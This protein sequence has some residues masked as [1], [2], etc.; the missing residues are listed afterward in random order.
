MTSWLKQST[1]GTIMLG[2]FV[3]DTDGK[4]AETGLTIA[5]TAVRLSKAGAAFSAASGTANLSHGENGWYA[6]PAGTAD[7]NTLGRLDIACAVSGA[8]PVWQ[9]YM[10]LS[11]Q[12]YNS[13][14]ANS[15]YLDVNVIEISGDS[16]AADNAEAF[17][18]GTGYAG[19]NNVIPSVTLVSGGTTTVS[20]ASYTPIGTAVWGATTRLITG[21]TIAAGTVTAITNPVSVSAGTVAV[22]TSVTNPVTVSAGTTNVAAASYTPIGTAVWGS[23]SR[24]ITGGTVQAGT[25]NVVTSVAN[26]VSVN[27][28]TVA[29]AT[30]VTN[31]VQVSGGT[32]S[33]G[34]ITAAGTAVEA[35]FADAL[36][37]R[38]LGTGTDS[39]G[40]TVRNAL[41]PLVNKVS[42]VGGTVYKEDDSTSAWTFTTTT[43]GAA[44]PITVIDPA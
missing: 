6:W 14:A 36:L 3:D 28:G 40:R 18:D 9:H 34:T 12:V 17:F 15:D 44:A 30:S 19:T 13:L 25:I 29:V 20:A 35:E 21:G 1:A 2:P 26:P 42:V 10:V 24:L 38:N 5:G 27:A 4:T 43:D 31:P 11:S 23:A 39:G 16:T 22:A 41:R 37:N 33:A 32:I 8:L 7:T